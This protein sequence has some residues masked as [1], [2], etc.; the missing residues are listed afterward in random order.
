M[1]EG[2]KGVKSNFLIFGFWFLFDLLID[3]LSSLSCTILRFIIF[4]QTTEGY[5]LLYQLEQDVKGEKGLNLYE[6]HQTKTNQGDSNDAVP[7][8]R[9]TLTAN[10]N[11]KV[12]I[13]RYGT[14]S[15]NIFCQFILCFSVQ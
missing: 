2:R 8:L 12:P 14:C 11:Y 9:L 13:T 1:Q 4:F 5:L 10:V 3:W 7:A 6:Y 15:S